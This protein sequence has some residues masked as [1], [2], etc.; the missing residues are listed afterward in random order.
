MQVRSTNAK[1]ARAFVAMIGAAGALL[2][3]A[4]TSSAAVLYDASVPRYFLPTDAD[5]LYY[6]VGNANRIMFDDV[7]VTYN[8]AVPNPTAVITKAT[9]DI[10]RVALAPSVVITAYYAPMVLD[11]LQVGDP[12]PA[13]DSGVFDDPG[14]PVS[15]GSITLNASVSNTQSRQTI[16]FGNGVTPLF[17]VPLDLTQKPGGAGYFFLGLKFSTTT[18]SN[19]WTVADPG[20]LDTDNNIAANGNL[21]VLFDYGSPTSFQEFTYP[22]DGNM[23]LIAGA[24][25]MHVEGAVVPEPIG[26]GVILLAGSLLARRSRR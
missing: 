3:C 12:D 7:P 21:D 1:L 10:S 9:F 18:R 4:G 2:S 24:Q 11:S 15:F 20:A 6:Q 19:G 8:N 14:P 5:P 23:Q 13:N 16:S 17:T 26:A 25:M 22:E